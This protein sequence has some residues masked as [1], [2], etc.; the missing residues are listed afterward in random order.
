MKIITIVTVLLLTMTC[1]GFAG[2]DDKASV[3]YKRVICGEISNYV[4]ALLY[5]NP[6]GHGSTTSC[7]YTD[8]RLLIKPNSALTHEQMKHFVFLTFS[9]VGALL[10]NGYMLPNNIYVGY[11]GDCQVLTAEDTSILQDAANYGGPSGLSN[12]RIWA[13]NAPKWPCP[14]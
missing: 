13:S 10:N 2:G 11:G 8:E 9:A 7:S 5:E 3:S 4:D 1:L 6:H 12:A 14:K